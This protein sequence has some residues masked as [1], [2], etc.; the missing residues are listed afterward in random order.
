M[1]ASPVP[2]QAPRTDPAARLRREIW[3]AVNTGE[4]RL[5]AELRARLAAL[6]SS[7]QPETTAAAP[8]ARETTSRTRTRRPHVPRG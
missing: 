4:H 5:A 6:E 1:T 3:H 7:P 8:P 2:P